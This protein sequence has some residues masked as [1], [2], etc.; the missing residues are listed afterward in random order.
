ML[1]KNIYKFRKE[2]GISQELLAEKVKVSRQTISN[3]EQKETSPNPEQLILLAEIFNIS[4]DELVGH[5]SNT[6]MQNTGKKDNILG[7]LV[8]IFATAMIISIILLFKEK[9]KNTYKLQLTTKRASTI[10]TSKS[11]KNNTFIRT[12]EI[13]SLEKVIC[14]KDIIGCDDT[15]YKVTLKQCNKETKELEIS[16][17]IEFKKLEKGKT[18]EFIFEPLLGEVYYEDNIT[19]IFAFNKVDSINET[20]NKCDKQIQ[21]PIKTR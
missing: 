20:K 1:N 5:K 18:Y 10:A 19:N 11:K 8:I 3:W 13:L 7:L 4:V 14:D 15:T 12:Y 21:D 9:D 16:N 2:R 6:I 17:S